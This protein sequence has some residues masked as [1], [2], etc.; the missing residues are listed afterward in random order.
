[1]DDAAAKVLLDW[2]TAWAGKIAESTDGL[3]ESQAEEVMHPRLRP[4]RRLMRLVNKWIANRREM[5]NE[6]SEALLTKIIEQAGIIY[7]QDFT[8]PDDDQRYAFSRQ[9]IEMVDNPRQMIAN[10]RDLLESSIT[11]SKPM[12]EEGD[13]KEGKRHF[14]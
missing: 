13:G 11:T 5:D 12:R 8:P 4:T 3:D 9:Q 7:G 1:L 10:L 6:D 2:G 14:G